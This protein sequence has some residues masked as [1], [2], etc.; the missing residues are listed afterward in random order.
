MNH[1]SGSG[2]TDP[3]DMR[4]L[5]LD[6]P[7]CPRALVQLSLLLSSD[8]TPLSAISALVEGDMALASAVVRTVNSS[9]FGLTRR[10]ETVGEAVRYLGTSEVTAITFEIGLRAA[11]TP[12]PE[13]EQLWERASRRGMLMGRTAQS[14]GM[15]ALRAHTAGLFARCGQAVL[16]SRAAER[17]TALLRQHGSDPAALDQAEMAGFGVTQG[18]LGSALCRAWGL[19]GEV[20]DYVREQARP[21]AGWAHLPPGVRD[22][23]V[24]GAVVD[25]LLVGRDAAAV[26]HAHSACLTLDPDEVVGAAT[27][28][29]LRLQMAA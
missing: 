23:L 16:L 19:A 8:Q 11:F 7:A 9:T 1:L 3:A 6:L 24:L 13:L 28:H 10:V 4:A 22:L 25:A 12:T 15:D 18:A 26:V 14:L 2:M 29:W 27:P 20:A 21:A 5:E 17:Y